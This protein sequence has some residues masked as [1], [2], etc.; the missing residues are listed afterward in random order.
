M[1]RSDRVAA[2]GQASEAVSSG[3]VGCGGSV[4]NIAPSCI[5]IAASQAA[6]HTPVSGDR[7]QLPREAAPE[8]GADDGADL[9]RTVDVTD[10][11]F[12]P[13]A[14]G[15]G[16]PHQATASAQRTQTVPVLSGT[17]FSA[18]FP[19]YRRGRGRTPVQPGDVLT[20]SGRGSGGRRSPRLPRGYKSAGVNLAGGSRRYRSPNRLQIPPITFAASSCV[21]PPNRAIS[22]FIQ[23]MHRDMQ[24]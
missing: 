22:G 14:L 20:G 10:R 5:L 6:P 9:A 4:A 21:V 1:A 2:I 13:S 24:S 19:V 8:R 15:P 11:I 23:S 16:L 17:P 3:G 7:I 12:P 18:Q